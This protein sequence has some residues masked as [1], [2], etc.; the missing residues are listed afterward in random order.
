M[1]FDGILIFFYVDDIVLAYRKSEQSR[2]MGLISQLKEH[3]NISGRE[4]PDP[5]RELGRLEQDA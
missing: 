5:G 4:V 1:T 2:A 3:F